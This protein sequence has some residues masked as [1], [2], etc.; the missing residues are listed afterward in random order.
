MHIGPKTLYIYIS[1]PKYS[2]AANEPSQPPISWGYEFGSLLL[3]GTS[4]KT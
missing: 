1:T 3:V 4:I 2:G